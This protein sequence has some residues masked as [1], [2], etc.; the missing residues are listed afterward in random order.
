[1]YS[2]EGMGKNLDV[3]GM[4]M[5]GGMK[6]M[7]EIIMLWGVSFVLWFEGGRGMVIWGDG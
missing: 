2:G 6:V 4:V 3:S 1:M 7:G 5:L